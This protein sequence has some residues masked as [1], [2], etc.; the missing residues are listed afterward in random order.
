MS[1]RWKFQAMRTTT[2]MHF[3]KADLDD[4]FCA[5]DP[6]GHRCG[7]MNVTSLGLDPGHLLTARTYGDI[8]PGN[9]G[10]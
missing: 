3:Y 5:A 4:V 6:S 1:R 7:G 8:A 9:D 2:S 10:I